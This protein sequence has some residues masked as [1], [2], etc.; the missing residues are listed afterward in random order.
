MCLNKAYNDS[1]RTT[2]TTINLVVDDTTI[3]ELIKENGFGNWGPLFDWKGKS[4]YI[5]ENL[6]S[7]SSSSSSD[8]RSVYDVSSIEVEILD[9]LPTIKRVFFFSILIFKNEKRR[10]KIQRYECDERERER[11]NF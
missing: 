9:V 6:D 5:R 7:S 11:Q 4:V 10:F 2:T 3:F 8:D 1:S